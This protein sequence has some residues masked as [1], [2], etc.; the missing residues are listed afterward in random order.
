MLASLKYI[1]QLGLLCLVVFLVWLLVDWQ[2]QKKENIR[3]S[4]NAQ[5]LRMADSLKFT[6][7]ILTSKE[8]QEYLNFQN[9]HLQKL[10]KENNIKPSRIEKII[11]NNYYYKDTSNHI[12]N[13]NK[14]INSI[15]SGIPDSTNFTDTTACL[16]IQGKLIYDGTNLNV[17]IYNREFKN[18]TNA[19]VYWQRKQWKFLGFK[20]RIFGKKEFTAK[21]FDDC[22]KSNILTIQ[23]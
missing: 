8:L 10:L 9:Q 4:H 3:Q 6:S 23:K 19:V 12:A 16:N 14:M 1:K 13:V 5:Q 2:F 18:K 22:G 20:T 17:A 11:S 7:Q 15:R 21:V